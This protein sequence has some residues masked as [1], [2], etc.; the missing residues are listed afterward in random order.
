MKFLLKVFRI[1]FHLEKTEHI[2]NMFEKST[3]FYS[4]GTRIKI[5]D[6]QKCDPHELAVNK[7]Q[8]ECKQENYKLVDLKPEYLERF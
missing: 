1:I 6:S 5:L 8:S 2:E 7:S 3:R 4:L